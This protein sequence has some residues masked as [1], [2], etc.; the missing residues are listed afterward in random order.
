MQR[1]T[2]KLNCLLYILKSSI[3]LIVVSINKLKSNSFKLAFAVS[4]SRNV[5]NGDNF[6]ADGYAAN[7]FILILLNNYVITYT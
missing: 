6:S 7:P 2:I 5:S 4:K 1:N 3:E